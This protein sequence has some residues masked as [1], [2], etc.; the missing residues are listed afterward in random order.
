MLCGPPKGPALGCGVAPDREDELAEAGGSK[1]SMREEP[2]VK[3]GDREH[4][5][6]IERASN[7]ESGPTEANPDEAETTA[8]KNE[9]WNPAGGVALG[10]IG[11]CRGFL[12]SVGIQKFNDAA[13]RFHE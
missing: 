9:V 6:D 1:C 5:H 10:P 12:E 7:D 11:V 4:A 2:V 3:A 13:K 8:V